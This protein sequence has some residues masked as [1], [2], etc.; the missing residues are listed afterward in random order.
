MRQGV[1]P[2]RRRP[3][4]DAF[5]IVEMMIAI[6]ILA[7]VFAAVYSCWSAV[8]R[9]TQIG[10]KAA[11]E[12][13]R[14][15]MTH[16]L[17]EEA[18]MSAV[19]HQ[20]NQRYYSFVAD[21]TTEFASLS[22]VSRVPPSFPGSGVFGK[23]NLRRL[24]FYVAPDTNGVACLYMSQMPML[25]ITNDL[26]EPYV[27]KLA[28]GVSEFRVNFWNG[29][30]PGAPGAAGASGAPAV[31]SLAG[32]EWTDEWT[33]TNRL[34]RLIQYLITTKI[35]AGSQDLSVKSGVVNVPS[36][37]IPP[38]YQGVQAATGGGNAPRTRPAP[39]TQPRR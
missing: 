11:A 27:L 10:L 19:M 35:G 34:P 23:L 30:A 5:T 17:L 36:M 25:L 33:T 18:L 13:H 28:S 6:G 14:E 39:L 26:Q 24:S 16:R 12:A 1:K 9:G 31:A 29:G 8:S 4:A 32:E 15:H 20:A 22:F 3:L 38:V 21:T 2:S 7:A 37:S